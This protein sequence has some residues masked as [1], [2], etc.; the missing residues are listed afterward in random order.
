MSPLIFPDEIDSISGGGS[1]TIILNEMLRIG[2]TGQLPNW[3]LTADFS[4]VYDLQ[5]AFPEIQN[6]PVLET[7]NARYL[8][9]TNCTNLV[10][11]PVLKTGNVITMS[12]GFTGCTS[13]SNESLNNIMQMCI[14]ATHYE[15]GLY[16]RRL[17][18][19]GLT[20]EQAEICKTL[21]NYQAFLDAGWTTGY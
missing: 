2:G 11:L 7:G 1:D 10:T 18:T 6:I 17:S 5:I 19:I 15:T 20:E 16:D 4:N 14:N 8:S 3:F 12:D 21:S 13:L 9:F